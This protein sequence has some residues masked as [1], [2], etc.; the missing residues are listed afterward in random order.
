M[1]QPQRLS[2]HFTILIALLSHEMPSPANPAGDDDEKQA[3]IIAAIQKAGGKATP[4]FL[5]DG[6]YVDF[7]GSGLSDAGLLLIKEL[8]NIRGLDLRGTLIT[9]DGLAQ[10]K[11]RKWLED[12]A[13]GETRVTDSG[14]AHLAAIPDLQFL[15]L[16]ATAVSDSGLVHL[17]KLKHLRSLDL[18][19]T[20]LT[21]VGI[22]KIRQAL[23]NVEIR[24]RD[25]IPFF[26]V[27]VFDKDNKEN[28]DLDAQE[29]TGHLRAMGE[30]PLWNRGKNDRETAIVR[31]LWLPSFHH[32]VV[33]RIVKSGDSVMLYAIELDGT[34]TTSKGKVSA[35]KQAKL[36]NAEW[37]KL[38]TYLEHARFWEKPTNV[39]SPPRED[40]D[41]LMCE[42]IA[43]DKYHI[44]YRMAVPDP[45]FQK[46]CRYLLSLSGLDVMEAWK[47]YHKDE[48]KN[49]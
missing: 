36:T 30:L 23:P 49:K 19:D 17:E 16:R 45:D 12:L 40:G 20:R 26:P 29:I 47:E 44:V 41:E 11:G 1:R 28:D 5:R 6:F 2:R 10:L 43:D 37:T 31:L 38:Q 4:D 33:V 22:A 9:N 13:L 15:D 14:L 32:P 25:E 8:D 24:G 27:G 21:D 48:S 35:K 42:G 46:L 39:K 34:P 18:R 7:R 3:A